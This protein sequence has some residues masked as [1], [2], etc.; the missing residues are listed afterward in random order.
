MFRDRVLQH[1]REK[2]YSLRE[3]VRVRGSSGTVHSCD[4]VAQGP[5]GNLV[6]QFEDY[7]GFEG[8][9]LDAVRRIARDVGATPVVAAENVSQTLRRHADQAGVVVMDAEALTRASAPLVAVT[10]P[11]EPA[12]PPWPGQKP[13]REEVR[14][15]EWPS[16][17]RARPT[18]SPRMDPGEV[19]DL[20]SEWSRP[21]PPRPTRREDPGFW[22]YGGEDDAD[23]DGAA[24]AAGTPEATGAAETADAPASVAGFSWLGVEQPARPDPTPAGAP[25]VEF[26]GEPPRQHTEATAASPVTAPL[27]LRRLAGFAVAGAVAGATFLGLGV[28][29]GVL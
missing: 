29:F 26:Y 3:R 14:T 8:P 13:D 28:L 7:G 10:T 15:H 18:V 17:A 22:K 11:Q 12:Y 6:V 25:Q 2:G 5:L 20:V 1:Y 16:D 27:D 21:E 23:A 9:E 4:V 24:D 19:D